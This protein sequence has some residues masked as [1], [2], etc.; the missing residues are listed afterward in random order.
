M[1]SSCLVDSCHVMSLR[2]MKQLARTL[3][4][5][6]HVHTD[7]MGVEQKFFVAL[8]GHSGDLLERKGMGI[9]LVR[10]DDNGVHFPASQALKDVVSNQRLFY[11][12]DVADCYSR[13]HHSR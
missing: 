9:P 10:S 4:G 3:P 5:V 1:Y 11:N 7:C 2:T 12:G 8:H 6:K 13:F